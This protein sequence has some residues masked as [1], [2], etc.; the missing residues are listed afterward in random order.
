MPG[1][2]FFDNFFQP[3]ETKWSR[4]FQ[5]KDGYKVIQAQDGHSYILAFNTVGISPDDIKVTHR[6]QGNGMIISVSGQSKIPELNDTY[7]S[8]YMVRLAYTDGFEGVQYKVKDGLTLV[9]IKFK[10]PSKTSGEPAK[11]IDPDTNT[12]W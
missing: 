10:E 5:E 9:Y 6:L 2:D 11:R 1:D 4:F 3:L 7:S 12:D 8:D